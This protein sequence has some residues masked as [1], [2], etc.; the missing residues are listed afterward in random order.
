M[1]KKLITTK[2]LIKKLIIFVFISVLVFTSALPIPLGQ[3]E[4]T[5]L[6]GMQKEPQRAIVVVQT[7]YAAP[8]I[9]SAPTP[10]PKKAIYVLPGFL[11]S[12]LYSQRNSGQEI[13]V[14]VGI[15]AEIASSLRGEQPEMANYASGTGMTAYA[16]RNRDKNGVQATY[17]P[18]LNSIRTCLDL[19][20]LSDT[21][22]V[23]FFSYNSLA[24]LNDTARDLAE[25]IN[26]KGYEKVILIGHS[27]GGLLM[28]TFVAQSRENRS[29]VEKA[30]G[31]AAP[32]WGAYSP[33]EP[34][35]TGSMTVF[36]G[37]LH[38]A[39]MSTGND[40]LLKPISKDWAKAWSQNSP[41]VY[42][43]LPG[44]EYI[45]R[46]PI[47]Y[48]SDSGVRIINNSTDYYNLL[49]ASS[50][51]NSALV[52]SGARSLKHLRENVYENDVLK[53]W[54]GIDLTMIGCEYGFFTPVSVIYRQSGAEIIYDGAIFN[55]A[56]DGVIAG[57]SMNGD[58]RVNFVN[59]PGTD[60]YMSNLDPRMM[61]VVNEII[62]GKP[63]SD[64]VPISSGLPAAFF[65]DDS[66]SPSVG[67][68]D[69]IRVELKSSDPLDATL[70]NSGIRINIYNSRGRTVAKTIGDAQLGF[71][72]NNFIFSSWSTNDYATNIIC[73]IP[74]NGYMMEV[75]TGNINRSASDIK[76]VIGTLDPSGAI[77]SHHEYRL[78]GATL[79]TGS[80]FTLDG[81]KSMKPANSRGVN[82]TEL[83]LEIY[84]QDY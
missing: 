30:I 65:R 71:A 46:I 18:L 59:L 10:T 84:K 75:L 58:G 47:V 55:K 52:D 3:P 70:T 54:E 32:L 6:T 20:G 1:N 60:H 35:E 13:W 63:V 27:N 53:H 41:N 76:V 57:M 19:H 77:L 80:V 51:T 5:A 28:S 48:R 66:A 69:M 44:N 33:L 31:I 24:D 39:L 17:R 12:R 22:E 14:G 36:N 40:F 38:S 9:P 8:V 21:Y 43:L 73:Y 16:D 67:M 79:I 4:F 61:H 50:N 29:K 56:G 7:A 25:D 62:L 72:G 81:S 74:K 83:S 26:A 82:L 34:V 78:T 2:K 42:Q 68:S 64:I 11:G 37:S 49:K 23:E 45:S 15:V